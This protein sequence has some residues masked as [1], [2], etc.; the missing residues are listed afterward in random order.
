MQG[1]IDARAVGLGNHL[2]AAS[3]V[4]LKGWSEDNSDFQDRTPS[5][6]LIVPA[7]LIHNH[8]QG[9]EEV[10]HADS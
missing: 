6:K 1:Q 8:I 9:E 3:G 7:Q 2:Y 5:R 4:W 10:A